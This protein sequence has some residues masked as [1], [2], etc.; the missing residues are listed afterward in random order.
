MDDKENAIHLVKRIKSAMESTSAKTVN[1]TIYKDG[2]EFP[3]KTKADDLRRDC[4]SSYSSWSI[5]A[6]DR[7]RFE[8]LFGKYADYTPKDICCITYGRNVLYRVEK[9]DA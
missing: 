4:K 9:E 2:I 8:E 7:R 1:V 6:A 5:A 3:F